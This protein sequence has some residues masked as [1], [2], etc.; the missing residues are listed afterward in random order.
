MKNKILILVISLTVLI[1]VLGTSYSYL[2]AERYNTSGIDMTLSDMD[3]ILLTDM[4]N[5]TLE[6]SKPVEDATGVSNTPTTFQ[7]QNIGDE[8]ANYKVS[9]IDSDIVVSTI[10][11]HCMRYQLKR[12]NQ[13]TSETVTLEINN[14]QDDGV[15]D[16]G[17]IDAG[18][19]YTYELVLWVGYGKSVSGNFAKVLYVEGRQAGSLDTSGANY[20]EL[21]DN[22]IPVY[23]DKTSDTAGVW[24]IAD[25]TNQNETYKWFDYSDFMWANAVTVKENGTTSRSDYLKAAPGTQVS[26]DDIV[27]MWVWIPRYKYTIFNG[28]NGVSTEQMINVEFEHGIDKTGTVTCTDNILTATNSSSSETCVDNV[29]GSIING[30]STYT[31][32]A[33]SFGE[34]EL[35]GFWISK[36]EASTDST[37][38]STP[39]EANCNESG[40][41]IYS[42]PGVDSLS[43]QNI[44]VL[45]ANFR[46][47]ELYNNIHGFKQN[48]SATS[49]FDGNGYVT[50]EISNDNN[51]ID[52]HMI[53]NMEWGAIAYLSYSNYGKW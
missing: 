50:G 39:S 11:N 46:E 2:K 15:I 42:K 16:S 44:S 48:E 8:K 25:S 5:V 20:P 4:T 3:V 38:L 10:P 12:T 52:T 45:F 43:Y 7:I 18:V 30:V 31:H 40:L 19:I 28:N 36:F 21:L 35:T 9:L 14:L 37:C 51:N 47:M 26:D 6:G 41:N 32:P 1:G 22:M 24:R 13:S 53:K 29:N 34:E 17:T 33:F 23:Y 49:V 27:A